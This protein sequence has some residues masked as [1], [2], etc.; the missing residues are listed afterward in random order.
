MMIQAG[1]KRKQGGLIESGYQ[2]SQAAE[3]KQGSRLASFLGLA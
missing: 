2:G 3:L 1:G